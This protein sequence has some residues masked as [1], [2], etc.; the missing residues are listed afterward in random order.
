MSLVF[1][2]LHVGGWGRVAESDLISNGGESSEA[3][4]RAGLGKVWLGCEGRGWVKL[5]WA[6]V[7]CGDL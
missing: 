5:A 2:I 1:F 7:S 6:E 4:V 3:A